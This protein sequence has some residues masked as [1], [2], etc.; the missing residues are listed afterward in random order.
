M[1]EQIFLNGAP[2]VGF[3]SEITDA[4]ERHNKALGVWLLSFGVGAIGGG[5]VGYNSGKIL[6]AVGGVVVGGIVGGVA[7]G[8]VA[9][10][11]ASPP[12]SVGVSG[13][14]LGDA[15]A[16]PV[17]AVAAITPW[18]EAIVASIVGAATSWAID[19]AVRSTRRRR[20]RRRR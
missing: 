6:G 2:V 5:V 14:G 10:A 15:V 9:Y 8:A 20:R 16:T 4:D 3:G 17:A 11:I 18:K 12:K 19:G 1:N 7:G 13:F